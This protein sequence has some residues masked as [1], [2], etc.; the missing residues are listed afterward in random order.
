MIQKEKD[1]KIIN[2]CV[3]TPFELSL[4]FN[5]DRFITLILCYRNI[6]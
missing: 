4:N 1:E 6:P 2:P 5:R 3:Y